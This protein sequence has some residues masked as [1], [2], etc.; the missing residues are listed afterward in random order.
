MRISKR[1]LAAISCLALL[2]ADQRASA[3]ALADKVRGDAIFTIFW[4]GSSDLGPDYAKSHL[5]AILEQSN[6]G[7]LFSQV[8]PGLTELAQRKN[9]RLAQALESIGGIAGPLWHHPV[10]IHFDGVA[11]NGDQPPAPKLV[12]I[13]DAGDDAAGIRGQLDNA[14][15]QMGDLPIHL[16]AFTQQNLVGIECGYAQPE[17]AIAEADASLAHSEGFQSAMKQI[18]PH[19]VLG[20]FIQ[21]KPLIA[22]ID[23]AVEQVGEP[24][25]SQSWNNAKTS[26][27]FEGI[28]SIAYGAAFSGANWETRSFIDAPEPRKGLAEALANPEP[29]SPDL[30]AIVPQSATSLTA[31]HLD[32]A[33]AVTGIDNLLG[34]VNPSA[35]Q[36]FHQGLGMAQMMI[37]KNIVNDVL[38][39]LGPQWAIY[40]T[41][42]IGGGGFIGMVIVNKLRDEAKAKQSLSAVTLAIGNLASSAMAQSGF[43]LTTQTARFGDV[44]VTYLATPYVTPAWTIKN[45]YLFVGLFPQIAGPA[46]QMMEARGPSITSNPKYAAAMKKLGAESPTSI[47]YSDPAQAAAT[48]YQALLIYSRLGLGFSDMAGVPVPEPIMPPFAVIL[49]NLDPC[50]AVTWVDAAGLYGRSTAPFPGSNLASVQGLGVGGSA[51]AVSILLPSL[52]RARETANRV[53]CASNE[54]QMG[55]CC[56]LWSNDHKGKLPDTIADMLSEDITAEVFICPSANTALPKDFKTMAAADQ[57]QWLTD[58]GDYVYVGA[59]KTSAAG[60]DEIL[61]YEK[62]QDHRDGMNILFGDGR[63]EYLRMPQAVKMIQDQ[64]KTVPN[65]KLPEPPP[66]KARP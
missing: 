25:V 29:V 44:D 1:F 46:A 40:S 56:L 2:L 33:A 15:S 14:V 19:P 22:L 39:P 13:S 52:N 7:L 58:H 11:F 9:P 8:Y 3:Q 20:S 16:Q 55:Q 47:S 45:G 5:Q 53:K 31:M 61:V 27:N 18:V 49:Q 54:R 38:K 30:L 63:V 62:P 41:P 48:I 6:I 4:S 37:G 24:Q 50:A 10:A 42:E 57:G 66:G 23:Q 32:L 36:T 51:L 35:Q 65:V 64:N 21:V 26:A 12:L 59:G 43:T 28:H 17:Q 60:A 34:E